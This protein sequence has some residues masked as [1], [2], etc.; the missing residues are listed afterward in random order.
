MSNG[1]NLTR[2]LNGEPVTQEQMR[3]Q[4]LRSRAFDEILHSVNERAGLTGSDEA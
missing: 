1:L 2:T 4:V 3:S